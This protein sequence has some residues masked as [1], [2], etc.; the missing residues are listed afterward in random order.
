VLALLTT[1]VLFGGQS[2]EVFLLC[3]LITVVAVVVHLATLSLVASSIGRRP[4]L[5][6]AGA[7]FFAPFGYLI[8]YS[9][10]TSL[11]EPDEPAGDQGPGQAGHQQP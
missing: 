4:L 1:S 2:V 3:L 8:A 9:R 10:L 11:I 7:I 5:W 6:L